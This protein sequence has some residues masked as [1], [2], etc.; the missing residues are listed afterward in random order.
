M[1]IEAAVIFFASIPDPYTIGLNAEPGWRQPSPR[2]SYCGWNFLLPRVAVGS[3]EP[4]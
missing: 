3:A 4:W 2:T 1:N